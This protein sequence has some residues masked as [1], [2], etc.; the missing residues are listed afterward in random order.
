M[1]AVDMNSIADLERRNE[2]YEPII[3]WC[4]SMTLPDDGGDLLD[5]FYQALDKIVRHDDFDVEELG[6]AIA[7]NWLDDPG[8]PDD[9]AE[10]NF[11]YVRAWA[12]REYLET[13]GEAKRR[14]RAPKR[15]LSLVD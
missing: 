5:E 3:E 15:E 4:H 6:M 2:F 12:V 11:Y 9:A 13:R 14:E 7:G 8:D 1:K 10:I